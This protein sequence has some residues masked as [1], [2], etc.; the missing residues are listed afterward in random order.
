MGAASVLDTALDLL[1]V[2]RG[3]VEPGVAEVV[4]L[5]EVERVVVPGGGE[6]VEF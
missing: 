1:L 4:E 5:G 2:G 3:V 6:G